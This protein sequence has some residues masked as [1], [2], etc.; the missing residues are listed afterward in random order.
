[1]YLCQNIN[2]RKN[3]THTSNSLHINLYFLLVLCAFY[4]ILSWRLPLGSVGGDNFKIQ[5]PSEKHLKTL[6]WH[7][8]SDE[9]AELLGEL[10]TQLEEILGYLNHALC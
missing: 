7:L 10:Q 2:L 6:C 8:S 1:V 4:I 3:K 9:L 5:I